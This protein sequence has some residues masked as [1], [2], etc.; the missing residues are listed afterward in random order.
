MF[1]LRRARQARSNSLAL[2]K[3]RRC[4]PKFNGSESRLLFDQSQPHEHA[5]TFDFFISPTAVSFV[6]VF[7]FRP[8]PR[9]RNEQQ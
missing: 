1:R 8:D 3:L 6:V 5:V 4:F 7:L 2:S 9:L